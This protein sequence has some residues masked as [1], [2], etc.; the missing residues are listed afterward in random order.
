MNFVKIFIIKTTSINRLITNACCIIL[1]LLPVITN[2]QQRNPFSDKINI[3]KDNTF[4]PFTKGEVKRSITGIYKSEFEKITSIITSWDSLN[5]PQGFQAYFWGADNSLEV[6]FLPY[7]YENNKKITSESGPGLI[8]HI[9]APLYMFG[10]P[11][12]ADIFLCP[13]KVSDFFGYPVYRNGKGE[14]TILS[15]KNIPLFIPVTREEYLKT[16][17]NEEG[18]N[19]ITAPTKSDYEATLN[20]MDLAYNKL[21]QTN[22]EAAREFKSQIE[23]FKNESNSISEETQTPNLIELLKTELSSMTVEEKNQQAYYGGAGAM[24]VYHNY[25]GLVPCDEKDKG[26]ALV[27][28]NPKLIKNNSGNDIELTVIRWSVGNSI[29]NYNPGLYNEDCNG[30]NLADCIFKSLYQD[31]IIWQNIFNLCN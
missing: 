20:E 17:I 13:Q 10:S 4:L 15:K 28:A 25:S 3:V 8:F 24:D 29:E 12:T 6:Y 19:K 14:V 7:L 9:N 5:P 2:A 21:L 23:E 31:Q 18:K 11:I 27:R 30:F 16:L 1:L 22:P 26:D